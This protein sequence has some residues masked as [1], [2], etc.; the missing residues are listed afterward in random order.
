MGKHAFQ[1]CIPGYLS[2]S[3][4]PCVAGRGIGG[5]DVVGNERVKFDIAWRGSICCYFGIVFNVLLQETGDLRGRVKCRFGGNEIR[6]E[7]ARSPVD[8][9]YGVKLRIFSS[10][11][12]MSRMTVSPPFL[13]LDLTNSVL[14]KYLMNFLVF[15]HDVFLIV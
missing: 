12:S 4:R 7:F 8:R 14:S 1:K 2:C 5:E 6:H 15:F 3:K 13:S 9:L 11:K 10:S